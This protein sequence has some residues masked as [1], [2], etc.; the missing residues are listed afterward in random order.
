LFGRVKDL[1]GFNR[2]SILAGRSTRSNIDPRLTID[3]N[4]RGLPGQLPPL[5]NVTVPSSSSLPTLYLPSLDNQISNSH[6]E[7]GDLSA[8]YPSG[9]L[10]PTITSTAHTGNY[11]VMLGG[12]V[13]TDTVTTGLWHSTIEQTISVSPTIMS[14]TLSL[15]YR[16]DA[17]DP[18]S[19][20]LNAY[21]VGVNN[22]LTFTLPVTT[23]DWA[24]TWFDV[25]T[26]NEPTATVKI[27]FVTGSAGRT[28]MALV[29]EIT[30]GSAV[31]GSHAVFLP[32]ARR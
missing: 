17:V 4:L 20:T 6:F 3:Q 24:H 16:A 13:P 23:S 25:S 30:W 12:T 18:M 32:I 7:S 11:A 19:D 14:G 1:G 5:L 28:T 21:L 22:I 27:D 10:T 15:L 8:W 9:K 29:D 26:W 31:E 2:P